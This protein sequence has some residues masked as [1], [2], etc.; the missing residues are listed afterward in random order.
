MKKSW[1][2]FGLVF[3]LSS[4]LALL[5]QGFLRQVIV[6]PLLYA[7]WFVRLCLESLPQSL[8]WALF[9][10][11][12][13]VI[14]G[15]SLSVKK[16]KSRQE[17]RGFTIEHQGKIEAWMERVRLAR[18]GN[19]FKVRLARRLAEFSLETLA[20][21]ERLA[22]QEIQAQLESGT[23]EAPQEIQAYLKAGLSMFTQRLRA[24]QASPLQLNP[25]RVVQFLEDL[26][27]GRR[28]GNAYER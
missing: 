18:R 11:V 25:E 1:L 22:P 17:R 10:G 5:F 14:A 8:L 2:P 21:R 15:K 19:Y 24:P 16:A 4:L 26:L 6:V 12:A 7:Y 27:Q 13:V 20:Y 9:I 28:E 3:A 23:L